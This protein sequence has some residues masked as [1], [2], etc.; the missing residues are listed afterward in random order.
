[1]LQHSMLDIGL[2]EHGDA[3]VRQQDQLIP[4]ISYFLLFL[5]IKSSSICDREFVALG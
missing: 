2:K 5:H 4:S 1:M 3:A